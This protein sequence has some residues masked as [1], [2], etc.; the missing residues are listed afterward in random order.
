MINAGMVN[1]QVPCLLSAHF[2]Y[3]LPVFAQILQ[4]KNPVKY[5]GI[6]DINQVEA[7]AVSEKT[8]AYQ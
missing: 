6:F 2:C 8:H 5:T 7:I 1:A 4:F 3:F